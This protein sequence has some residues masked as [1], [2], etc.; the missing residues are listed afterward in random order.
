[1][2]RRASIGYGPHYGVLGYRRC[3]GCFDSLCGLL[4]RIGYREERDELWFAGD[5]VNR[6]PKSLDVLRWAVK[7]PQLVSVL[8]NHD[9]HLLACAAGVAPKK[10]KDTLDDVLQAA[11]W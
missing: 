3:A 2:P 7:Q 9:V 4:D 11:D 1:M 5:L 10:R 6:G 8:G